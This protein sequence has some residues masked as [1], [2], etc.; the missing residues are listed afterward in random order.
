MMDSRPTF[1]VPK[2]SSE[3]WEE[4]FAGL[5][6]AIG[7]SAPPPGQRIYS[8]KFTHDGEVWTATVGEHLKGSA[9]RVSRVRGKKVERTVQLSNAST[10]M[11][12]FP[13]VPFHV[14]HDGAS[15][16]WANPFLTGEPLSI[17]Y[18]AA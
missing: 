18:F 10:V 9:D 1:F 16:T 14:W 5:A 2:V 8:I 6:R 15:P 12:I 17:A 13:G 11:A 4:C 3:K 7:Q